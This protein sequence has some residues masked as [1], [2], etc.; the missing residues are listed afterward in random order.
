MRKPALPARGFTL[1]EL[2][3]TV[4]LLAILAGLA[5]PSL[6]SFA[7]RSTMRTM[8]TDF[9]LGLQR[10]KLEAVNRNMCATMCMS[11]NA[12]GDS[13]TCDGTSTNWGKGWIVFLNPTCDATIT[14]PVA[15][16]I[17]AV[18]DSYSDRFSLENH[19]TNSTL[20]S[21]MFNAR[22]SPR[23][24][25]SSGFNLVDSKVSA[26]DDINRTICMDALGRV[27][28]VAYSSSATC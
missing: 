1:I 3:V 22:G 13:P 24:A 16:N 25:G 11:S 26:S 19:S 15:G 5:A 8:S 27:R 9:S 28:T 7:A 4:A 23:T 12:S 2:L 10:T 14:A 17:V 20:T 18:Q 21:I 6:S